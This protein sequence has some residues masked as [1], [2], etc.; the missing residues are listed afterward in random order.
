[1]RMA[2]ASKRD[3]DSVMELFH[4]LQAIESGSFPPEDEDAED[5]PSFDPDKK[6][7]LLKLHEKLMA[8]FNN[9]AYSRIMGAAHVL[10]N[11]NNRIIDQAKDYLDFH[12]RFA[13]ME[14]QRDELLAAAKGFIN[15]DRSEHLIVRLNDAE[16]EAVERLKTAVANAEVAH[17]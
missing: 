12:P 8:A 7:D 17:G 13:A 16:M 10:L 6:D 3:E 4:L 2:K 1:M 14:Q 9:G 5:W 11:E 15:A